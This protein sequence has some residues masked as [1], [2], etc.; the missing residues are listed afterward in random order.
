MRTNLVFI[1]ALLAAAWPRAQAGS[2]PD[3]SAYRSPNVLGHFN[4]ARL[5][6]LWYESAY[7]DIA[8]VGASCQTLNASYSAASGRVTMPFAVKYGPIP[9]TI[10]EVYDP[11]NATGMYLKHVNMPGGQLIKLNT[12]M[13]DVTASNATAPYETLTMVSC[14]LGVQEVVFAM[15]APL[16]AGNH[17]TLNKMKATAKGLGAKWDDSKLKE[18]SFDKC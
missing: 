5:T 8:Q 6:G 16:D 3:L 18:V 17:A 9:F 13:V 2:C 14:V 1:A 7:I 11:Q 10:V 4:P 12:V 15:R